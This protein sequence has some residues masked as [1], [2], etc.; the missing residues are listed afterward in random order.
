MF[1]LDQILQNAQGG[2][3]IN[4]LASQFGIS[5]EQADAAVKAF[6]PA[7][8]SG[9]LAKTAQPAGFNS[10]LGSL[11]ESQHMAA[12]SDPAAAQSDATIQKGNEILGQIFGSANAG[13]QIAQQASAMTGLSSTLLA[14][15]L[16]VIASM[17][18]GGMMTSLQNQGFG[19]ILGQLANAAGAGGSGG[20]W[21]SI[22]GQILG[23][24]P[25]QPQVQPAPQQA[26]PAPEASGFG[27]ILGNILGSVFGGAGTAPQAPAP[28]MQP[29]APGQFPQMPG[30]DP[31]SVQ[32]GLDALTKMFQPGPSAASG[33]GEDLQSEISD[34]L[35][36]RKR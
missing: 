27:N 35:G 19:G 8:S 25:G 7:L 4:N 17:L 2:Q 14:Q 12:F 22:L 15:M 36:G 5:P 11:G 29:G 21:G 1:N 6:I 13:N 20:G 30:F 3:A 24:G 26:P 32:A 33:Q 28:G 31:A 16:P 18:M 34:I 10:I 23:G 9:F